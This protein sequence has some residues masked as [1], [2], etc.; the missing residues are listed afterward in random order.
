MSKCIRCG[1]KIGFLNKERRCKLCNKQF[2]EKCGEWIASSGW[3][4]L[5]SDDSKDY[6]ICSEN[7]I[8]ELYNKFIK[9]SGTGVPLELVNQNNIG[10]LIK[11]DRKFDRKDKP[12]LLSIGYIKINPREASD[13]NKIISELEPLYNRIKEDLKSRRIAFIESHENVI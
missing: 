5:L 2:C 10:I 1:N 8:F 3:G 11:E 12:K 7:C 6:Q 13:E 9:T 4:T